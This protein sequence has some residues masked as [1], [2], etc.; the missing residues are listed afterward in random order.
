MT[1]SLTPRIWEFPD[2]RPAMAA[3]D[4][5][6]AMRNEALADDTANRKEQIGEC[7]A[8]SSDVGRRTAR[9]N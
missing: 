7:A 8:D 5:L 2:E 3:D 9:S 6:L 4:S 1:A